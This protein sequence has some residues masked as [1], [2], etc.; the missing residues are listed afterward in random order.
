MNTAFSENIQLLRD[1]LESHPNLI[2]LEIP[3]KSENVL[4]DLLKKSQHAYFVPI[5]FHGSG[6]VI[7]LWNLNDQS[8]IS[9]CPIVWLD[10]EGSP[11][12][13]IADNDDDF[14]SIL[15]YGTAIFY[16]LINAWLRHLKSPKKFPDPQTEYV[17]EVLQYYSN[18]TIES[19][20]KEKYDAF[21]NWLN[22]TCKI[23]KST[24]PALIIGNAIKKHPDLNKWLK[25]NR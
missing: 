11:N 17:D 4:Q 20:G 21:I 2:D 3:E 7:A 18:K 1:Y 24:N 13:V 14:L 25:E 10:S 6:S 12:S 8:T 5:V 22:N 19:A 23:K 16:D 9:C 15:P